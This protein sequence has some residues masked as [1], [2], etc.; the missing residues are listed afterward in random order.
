[1]PTA[2]IAAVAESAATT[3]YREAPNT[4]KATTGSNSVYSPVMTGVPAILV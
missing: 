2:R 4:A 1:M 3:K